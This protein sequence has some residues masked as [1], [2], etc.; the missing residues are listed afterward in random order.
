MSDEYNDGHT[1]E[2][3][4]MAAAIGDLFDR[5]VIETRCAAEFADV[6][7]KADQIGENLADLY[8]LIGSKFRDEPRI[9]L[10]PLSDDNADMIKLK[11]IDLTRS[12]LRP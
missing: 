3:L 7:A 6:K 2:A 10:K 4:H 12:R 1:H 5:W 8:Q 9:P 11:E